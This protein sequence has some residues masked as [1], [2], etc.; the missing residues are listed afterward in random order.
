MAPSSIWM[1]MTWKRYI[2]R[3]YHRAVQSSIYMHLGRS[4]EHAL[5]ISNSMAH[6]ALRIGF[7][8]TENC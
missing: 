8:L 5:P 7:F 3:G 6:G 2:W 1:R 4:Y